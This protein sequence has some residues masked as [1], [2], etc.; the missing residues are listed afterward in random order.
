[1]KPIFQLH[2]FQ[3]SIPV[4]I[5]TVMLFYSHKELI[6]KAQILRML[7]FLNIMSKFHIVARIVIADL[8]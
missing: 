5:I 3:S 4:S 6:T 1:M 7:N 8:E 2:R